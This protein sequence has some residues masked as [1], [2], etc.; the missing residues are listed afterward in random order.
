MTLI[1]AIQSQALTGTPAEV[2]SAFGATV[3]LP[4]NHDLW[5]YNGV[6]TTFGDTAAEGLAQAMSAAGL[7]TAVMVYASKGFD[8]SLQQTQDKLDAIAVGVPP[9]A[10]VCIALKAIG[11]P[12]T[13]RWQ[14]CGLSALPTEAEVAAAINTIA[15]QQQ[16]AALMNEVINPALSDPATTLA[17]LKA[18]IAAWGV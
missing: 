16:I 6:A 11:R 3:D 18:A 14:F 15:D 17:S 4:H 9:L 12:T 10:Q 8:L 7:T 2:V 1:N 5:S 13:T